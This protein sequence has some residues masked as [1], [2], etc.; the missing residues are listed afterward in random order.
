MEDIDSAKAATVSKA[1]VNVEQSVTQS[2]STYEVRNCR[3]NV[4]SQTTL[5]SAHPVLVE[6]LFVSCFQQKTL[7]RD[8]QSIEI[9]MT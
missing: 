2:S 7:N 4:M 1:C 9:G 3:E 6:Q 8:I 5:S